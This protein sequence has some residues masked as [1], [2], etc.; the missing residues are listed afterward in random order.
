MA[1]LRAIGSAIE[2]S[3]AELRH[4]LEMRRLRNCY[5][6]LT[7]RERQVMALV[8]SGL[9]NKQ[10]GGE[11]GINEVTVK[12]QRGQ[13]MRK[14]AADSLPELVTIAMRLELRPAALD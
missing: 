14:M 13:V 10:I 11:I 6:T 8:V 4:D 5:A 3:R 12:A 1:L 2:R 7:R 9:L